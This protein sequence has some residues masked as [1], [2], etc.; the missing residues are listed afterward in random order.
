[1][2]RP[3]RDSRTPRQHLV[4]FSS[5]SD[6]RHTAHAQCRV[7]DDINHAS[8]CSI[9]PSNGK[10]HTRLPCVG[11]HVML[12]ANS[13]FT[14]IKRARIDLDGVYT[15]RPAAASWGKLVTTRTT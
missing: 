12:E 8:M 6:L 13:A 10:E 9:L 5:R 2:L 4:S 14:T 3:A 15:P 1:M 11:G 7:L